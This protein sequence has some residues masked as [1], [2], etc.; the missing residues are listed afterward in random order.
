MSALSR[1]LLRVTTTNTAHYH[2][3]THLHWHQHRYFPVSLRAELDP[4][5]P[6]K[7][8]RMKK[9]RGKKRIK[10]HRKRLIKSLNVLFH[11][12]LKKT[13][14]IDTVLKTPEPKQK[15]L[16]YEYMSAMEKINEA[17]TLKQLS[18]YVD[19]LHVD[20]HVVA[21][22]KA[23][24]ILSARAND[25]TLDMQNVLKAYMSQHRDFRDWKRFLIRSVF[26]KFSRTLEPYVGVIHRLDKATSGVLVYARH[27]EAGKAMMQMFAAH[28]VKK[29]YIAVIKGE[30]PKKTADL[31]HFIANTHFPKVRVLTQ[32]QFRD[33]DDD[34]NELEKDED[35]DGD[36]VASA[37]IVSLKKHDKQRLKWKK[38]T[39]HYR[40]SQSF[41]YQRQQYSVLRVQCFTGRQHQI[42]A[43]LSAEG[44]PI[45]G[46][47][48][49]K[50]YV[51]FVPNK[52]EDA[53]ALHAWLLH[54]V[55]PLSKETKSIEAP[56]PDFWSD[57]F[58]AQI[59]ADVYDHET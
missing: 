4:N 10:A 24:G 20:A 16:S 59:H 32:Q 48:K 13:P 12:S 37:E 33:L 6:I 1:A 7:R 22:N 58:G 53:I 25:N 23:P 31:V 3:H 41:V 17:M 36:G 35:R 14:I 19:I 9:L 28:K 55:C 15:S 47:R 56:I 42:R 5:A 34:D 39:L 8:K 44:M 46:D 30:P 50:C 29:T 40:H 21:I 43:Q 52:N 27:E 45:V 54:Y 38:C 18:D 51:P 11:P 26:D 2:V 57:R 49:Y